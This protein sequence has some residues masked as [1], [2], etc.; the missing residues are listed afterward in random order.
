MNSHTK[1]L[2]DHYKIEI[3]RKGVE[4]SLATTA[5]IGIS[6]SNPKHSGFK[7]SSLI[8]WAANKYDVV[9]VNLHD[10]LQ[11][12]NILAL[13][14]VEEKD[15]YAQSHSAGDFWIT[16]NA[17]ILKPFKNIS[18]KRRDEL[19]ASFPNSHERL[20]QLEGLYAEDPVFSGLIDREISSFLDRKQAREGGWPS[21]K[22]QR[23]FVHSKAYILDELA[24][25]SLLNESQD[26]VEIY[27]GTF[28]NILKDPLRL[29]VQNLPEGLKN[30]P[31]VEVDFTHSRHNAPKLR[32]G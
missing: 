24:L 8:A 1:S 9:Q 32:A 26:F 29:Q 13:S 14:S 27:A 19:I 16:A 21:E 12:H 2:S 18:F 5:H 4:P 3:L 31:L 25:M 10:S 22:F 6:M 20:A 23:F 30:Y 11:R 7:F 15:A 17:H 28:L